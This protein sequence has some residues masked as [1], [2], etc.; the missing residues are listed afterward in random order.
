MGG[1]WAIPFTFS[2]KAMRQ[3]PDELAIRLSRSFFD[4]F[5]RGVGFTVRNVGRDGSSE[6]NWLLVAGSHHCQRER[7]EKGGR[8]LT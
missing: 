3:V 2:L 5:P 8:A 7:I 6:Q 4:F 1:N